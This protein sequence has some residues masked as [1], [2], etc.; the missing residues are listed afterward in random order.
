VPV[1]RRRLLYRRRLYVGLS[2]LQALYVGD[3]ATEGWSVVLK[4]S[5][6]QAGAIHTKPQL[7]GISK[8]RFPREVEMLEL[9]GPERAAAMVRVR[10]M[11]MRF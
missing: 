7:A 1:E 10:R 4:P 5:S 2:S 11:R 9:E 8:L 6:N 3:G